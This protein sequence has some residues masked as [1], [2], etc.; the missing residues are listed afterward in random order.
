[1]RVNSPGEIDL[2]C[3]IG[4][5]IW[6]H[7]RNAVTWTPGRPRSGA[8]LARLLTPTVGLLLRLVKNHTVAVARPVARSRIHQESGRGEFFDQDIFRNAVPAPVPGHS[9]N[10]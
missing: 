1:M 9:V 8:A 10:W 5:S 3:G 2:K 6:R 7:H 4:P